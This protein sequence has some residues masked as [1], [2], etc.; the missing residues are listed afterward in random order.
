MASYSK[1]IYPYMNSFY[2][3]EL[4]VVTYKI[5]LKKSSANERELFNWHSSCTMLIN[6]ETQFD[7]KCI[8]HCLEW[9]G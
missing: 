9:I 2:D 1:H 8:Y 3:C 4:I 5:Q 7:Y 6:L